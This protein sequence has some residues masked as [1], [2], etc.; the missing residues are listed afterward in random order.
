MNYHKI[1]IATWEDSS[2]PLGMTCRGGVVPFNQ[3]GYICNGASPSPGLDGG[4][5]PPLQWG[6]HISGDTIQ[7]NRLYSKRGGRQICRPYRRCPLWYRWVNGNPRKIENCQLST[8]NCQLFST[9]V[10]ALTSS[11]MTMGLDKNPFI[12]ASMACLRS[13]SKALA[14]MARMGMGLCVWRIC[15]VAV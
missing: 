12:P 15:F 1:K 7:P 9:F 14:V 8:V 4:R 5:L 6:Y 11:S 13:S 10:N 2:T 3:T